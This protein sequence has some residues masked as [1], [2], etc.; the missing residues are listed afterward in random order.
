V[1]H[2]ATL[3]RQFIHSLKTRHGIFCPGCNQEVIHACPSPSHSPSSLQP[4]LSQYEPQWSSTLANSPG[5]QAQLTGAIG[6]GNAWAE[7]AITYSAPVPFQSS[8][9]VQPSRYLPTSVTLGNPAGLQTRVTGP[10][11]QG[12]LLGRHVAAQSVSAAFEC[13]SSPLPSSRS[14]I[15]PE[16]TSNLIN[17]DLYPPNAVPFLT[18]TSPSGATSCPP[19]PPIAIHSRSKSFNGNAWLGKRDLH[20]TD[21]EFETDRK[22]ARQDLPERRTTNQQSDQYPATSSPCLPPLKD[23]FPPFASTSSASEAVELPTVPEALGTSSEDGDVT[24]E[25][26][27]GV[28]WSIRYNTKVKRELDLSF[29]CSL[30]L[31]EGTLVRCV[32][33]SKDGKYLAV[34]QAE[35]VA[36]DIYDVKTGEKT[37]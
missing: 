23:S 14:D 8:S 22:R 17:S 3:S 11:A 28:D 10:T 5:L 35:K 4:P 9:H 12:N 30:D 29:V 25:Q 27:N 1:L 20:P 6:Q 15:L 13:S 36:T 34:G 18:V 26:E 31:G 33:F 24:S 19:V 37:W 16:F 2:Q 7:Q 32:K 21:L